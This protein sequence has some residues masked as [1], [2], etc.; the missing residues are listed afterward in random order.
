MREIGDVVKSL[1]E[2]LPAERVSK[3][4]GKGTAS[5]FKY[6]K[7]GGVGFSMNEVFGPLGWDVVIRSIQIVDPP[8]RINAFGHKD[9]SPKSMFYNC[10]VFAHVCVKARAKISSLDMTCV[11]TTR[12]DV[13]GGSAVGGKAKSPGDALHHAVTAAV[14]TAVKRACRMFGPKTGLTL[15]FEA[16]E[17]EMIQRELDAA[18]QHEELVSGELEN[19]VVEEIAEEAPVEE[20]PEDTQLAST[21]QE[22]TEAAPAEEATEEVQAEEAPVEEVAAE[23]APAETIE[24]VVEETGPPEVL[25]VFVTDAELLTRIWSSPKA[26]QLQTKDVSAFHVAMAKAFGKKAAHAIW[27][28]AGVVPGKGAVVTRA[29]IDGV[30]QVLEEAHA[31]EGGIE[32]FIAQ[33]QEVAP[34]TPSQSAGQVS[35]GDWGEPD[36][37]RAYLKKRI[38]PGKDPLIEALVTVSDDSQVDNMVSGMLHSFA[39][40]VC[41]RVGMAA[42]EP[43]EI[44]K[45]S[46]YQ[47]NPSGNQTLPTGAQ[48]RAFF[49]LLPD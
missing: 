13:A 18:A 47:F 1:R 35:L 29:H 40:K 2:P 42:I 43:N 45:K 20:T 39:M 16:G 15:Q 9:D 48:A 21:N 6:M 33:Y 3:R 34:A 28:S 41:E 24:E 26:T 8:H 25:S 11:E 37:A 49:R 30:V 31:Q 23:E 22:S 7:V 14:S 12:E 4:T 46:G 10:L 17:Q 32:A 19:I 5:N 38:G 44:W 27:T 36:K